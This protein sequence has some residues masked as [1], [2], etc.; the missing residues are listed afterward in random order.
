MPKETAEQKLLK[1]IE[2][3]QGAGGSS[4][5]PEKK[6]WIFS[7]KN[8][9]RL[10]LVG[11]ILAATILIM[12]IL[13]GMKWLERDMA[14]DGGASLVAKL[15]V[16]KP[17]QLQSLSHYIEVVSLRN[18]FEPLE[19]GLEK[20]ADLMDKGTRNIELMVEKY[21]LVGIS[22]LESADTASVM[23]EDKETGITHFLRLGEKIDSLTVKT[24]YS[25]SA[26]LSFEDEEI[27]IKL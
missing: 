7:L 16:D 4:T 23:L 27:L 26:L 25:E 2:T 9:N 3:A 10:L 24:I 6:R 21:K 18:I 17:E 15:K 14:F 8:F 13:T 22:W 20:S 19:E 1:M 12:D 11:I 5:S